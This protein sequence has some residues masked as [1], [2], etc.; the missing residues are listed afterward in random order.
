VRARQEKE[1]R[2]DDVAVARHSG[3]LAKPVAAHVLR[4]V[5]LKVAVPPGVV[6]HHKNRHDLALR[7]RPTWRLRRGDGMGS[8]P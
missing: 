1:K 2:L 3:K 4:V 8:S 5:A 6:E 7:L